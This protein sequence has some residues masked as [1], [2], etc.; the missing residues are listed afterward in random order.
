LTFGIGIFDFFSNDLCFSFF[1]GIGLD[2]SKELTAQGANVV[3]VVRTSSEE[4]D[5]LNPAEIVKGIDVSSDE[6]CA[7]IG[8][9]VTG[10]PIDIVSLECLKCSRFFEVV[11]SL[12]LYSCAFYLCLVQ[13]ICYFL[14]VV[15]AH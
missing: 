1:T 11:R 15:I 13:K 6:T 3:A 10:G 5:A 12:T 7:T 9:K 2:L 14:L 4:L 8:G